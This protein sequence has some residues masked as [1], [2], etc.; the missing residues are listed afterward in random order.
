M[1]DN[2]DERLRI[3]TMPDVGKA[4]DDIGN[5]YTRFMN[6]ESKS[7]RIGLLN[8]LRNASIDCERKSLAL[9]EAFGGQVFDNPLPAINK[10]ISASV[11]RSINGSLH[12]AYLNLSQ[13]AKKFVYPSKAPP[14]Q[15][16]EEKIQLLFQMH[17]ICKDVADLCLLTDAEPEKK[18]II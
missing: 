4:L 17:V 14:Q 8:D 3:K 10:N 2:V 6:S 5:T 1:K 15:L 18:L 12:G 7:E 13:I 16:L 9:I 11:N